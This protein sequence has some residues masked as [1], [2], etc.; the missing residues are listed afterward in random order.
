MLLWSRVFHVAMVC[1]TS[2]DY[3]DLPGESVHFSLMGKEIKLL[4]ETKLSLVVNNV[5][6]NNVLQNCVSV[7]ACSFA[8][9]PLVNTL[10]KWCLQF[11][12]WQ[13][14]NK[15]T[16]K[17]KVSGILHQLQVVCPGKAGGGHRDAQGMIMSPGRKH[18]QAGGVCPNAGGP[19]QN[20]RGG[21]GL[22]EWLKHIL[23]LITFLKIKAVCIW[24]SEGG[25]CLPLPQ[26]SKFKLLA[27]GCL[28]GQEK[29]IDCSD[30]V[31]V[32]KLLVLSL[33]W[34]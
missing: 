19:E 20:L 15:N 18:R 14:R 29:E 32:V 33:R 17:K 12:S 34:G 22:R 31:P 10:H 13:I 24:V 1:T 30:H 9:L 28:H 2:T 7:R 4:Q 21:L 8:L 16:L 6:Q 27:P 5:L 3:R 26:T 11:C 23:A 25:I